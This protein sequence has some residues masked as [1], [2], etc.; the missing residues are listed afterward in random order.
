M[1]P[2]ALYIHW[3]FCLS[4][5]PYCDF[6]SHV[7]DAVDAKA[8]QQALLAE[9]DYWHARTCGRR[10]ASIFFGGGTPSLMP[11]SLVEALIE[12]VVARW[13][14]ADA[15]EITL[16]ANPTSAESGRFAAFRAGGVNRL[17]LGVQSLRDAEL[18]FLGRGHSSREAK[19]AIAL[20]KQH[21]PR[22]SFDLIYARP[23]QTLAD[24]QAELGEALALAGG[25]LSLYQLTIEENTAFHHAY[26][27]GGFTLPGDAESAALYE[28]TEA[29]T[30]ERGLYAYEVSNY[31]KPGEESRHN[32]AYWHGE[33]YLGIGP[34]A[35][36]RVSGEVVQP[37]LPFNHSTTA[38]RRT[39]TANIKSP[40]RWLSQVMA[41]GHGLETE[42]A[43]TG[44]E[45]LEERLMMGLRL[46]GGID[47]ARFLAQ[48]GLSLREVIA[49]QKRAFLVSQ[50][51]LAEDPARL[52]P[53][54]AGRLV[55]G[56][57]TA[58]L[59]Q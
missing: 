2:L 18:K 6:N 57:L 21:F 53:T 41:Q 51:L 4:K 54:L 28:L 19:Q 47:E 43:L 20:A 1:S 32:L 38:P 17:S 37:A 35:H 10:V 27:K 11:P 50:G 25:H 9:L 8:W 7:R 31:A 30:A 36:G 49:P 14:V 16:E 23:N 29:M 46:A 13:P 22:Y 5:C 52:R 3:P 12:R 39:A 24:W 44:Q 45:Q 48:T 34:G 59:C 26:A 56:A 42:Q 40:E 55:L 33:D 58:S 15:L